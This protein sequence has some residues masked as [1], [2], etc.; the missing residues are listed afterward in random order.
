MCTGYPAI[1]RDLTREFD[2]RQVKTLKKGNCNMRYTTART[3]MNRLDEVI[4]PENWWDR[5]IPQPTCVICELTIKLPDGSTI[6]KAD[7]GGHAGMSDEGDDEKSGYSDAFKR[8]AFKFGIGR[9][10]YGDGMPCYEVPAAQDA[11]SGP[12]TKSDMASYIK[13]VDPNL[14]PNGPYERL[15]AWAANQ[16]YPSKVN[17]WTSEEIKAGYLWLSSSLETDDQ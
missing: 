7:A 1:W 10:L 15:M 17:A 6:T 12:K 3:V 5:Y 13:T 14:K 2:S 4:G 11:Y 8:A 9:Y 16:G